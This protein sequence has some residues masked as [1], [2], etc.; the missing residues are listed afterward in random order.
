MASKPRINPEGILDWT[1]LKYG[2]LLVFLLHGVFLWLGLSLLRSEAYK[3]GKDLGVMAE[4]RITHL[5]H[6]AYLV[7]I[8]F[9]LILV[10]LAVFVLEIFRAN[11]KILLDLEDLREDLQSMAPVW[12]GAT[13]LEE[14]PWNQPPDDEAEEDPRPGAS[15]PG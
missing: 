14:D 3:V 10:V 5:L 9:S 11:Q 1:V 8:A 12:E 2:W 13:S 6:G 7:A 15:T 4:L